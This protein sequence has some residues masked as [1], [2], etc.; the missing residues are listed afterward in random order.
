MSMNQKKRQPPSS[1]PMF[2][3]PNPPFY[4]SL[5]ASLSIV[6]GCTFNPLLSSPL[7]LYRTLPSAISLT[8]PT[9][10]LLLVIFS[11]TTLSTAS[12]LIWFTWGIMCTKGICGRVLINTDQLTP[13]YWYLINVPIDTWSTLKQ[14]LILIRVST[15]SRA[16]F[17]N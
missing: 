4:Y 1:T 17:K 6:I 5:H 8:L 10:S 11:K 7:I 2:C 12:F 14:H 9:N 3:H 13:Q 15:D 16:S